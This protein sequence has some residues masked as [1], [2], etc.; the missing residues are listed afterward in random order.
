MSLLPQSQPIQVIHLHGS[1]SE[2]GRQHA[3]QTRTSALTGMATF[4]YDFWRRMSQSP[5]SDFL[6]KVLHR[7]GVYFIDPILVRRLMA[8]VPSFAEERIEGMSQVLALPYEQLALAL[9]L[10]DL[11]PMLQ[12]LASRLRPR[13]F[14]EASFPSL[15]GCSSFLY[16][17][18]TFLHGRNLDF[19]GVGYWDRYPIIQCIRRRGKIAYLGFASAG[20][21]FGGITGINEAQISVSLHQHYCREST[22]HGSLPFLIAE[23][24]LSEARS[25]DDAL[26]I[27]KNHRVST[28]W[29]FI[30]TDGKA[31]EGFVFECHPNACGVRF[32]R[33]DRGDVLSHSNYFQ[34]EECRPSEYATSARMNW[35]NYYRKTRLESLV[36]AHGEAFDAETAVKCISD[37]FDPFWGEEKVFNRTV[38]QVFNIQSLVLDPSQMRGWMA[39]GTAPVHLNQYE[40][41]D[42]GEI[43]S[44]REGRVGKQYPG[45]RFQDESLREAKQHYIAG[46]VAAF[47]GKLDL[48]LASVEMALQKA[49][50]AEAAQVAGVLNLKI[51]NSEKGLEW[52]SQA[53]AWIEGKCRNRQPFPPEYF[54]ICLF[55]SRAF[56]LLGKRSEAVSGYR[57]LS[58]HPQLEDSHLRWVASRETKYTKKQLTKLVLPFA[59]YVP[60]E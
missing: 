40:E 5:S 24:I 43:F 39:S 8:R 19:P 20:V 4:Y 57:E 36:K 2:I 52:L 53:R 25:L 23:E 30:V 11:F 21:P 10:P 32:L 42:L 51:G 50:I 45:F 58:R 9:V 41:F 14:V 49:F 56:D 46:F 3:E 60:F 47:D 59:T 17:G 27:L 33:R 7:I 29:A 34:T 44:G 18:K 38:S 16:S 6:E 13:Q 26:T 15:I 55:Q 35:D 22:L 1:E 54:E 12:A 28:S 37:H 48:A 31:K